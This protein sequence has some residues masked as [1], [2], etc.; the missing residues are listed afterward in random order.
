[1]DAVL[2]WSRATDDGELGSLPRLLMGHSLGGLIAAESALRRPWG[3]SGLV[4]SSPGFVVGEDSPAPLRAMA[5]LVARLL[6]W[7]PVEKLE[8]DDM[9]RVPEY[10]ADYEADPLVHHGGVPARSAGTML[11]GGRRFLSRCGALRTPTLLLGG[12]ADT[13]TA[14]R[15]FRRFATEAG[16]EHDP[17]PEITYREL[18]GGRHEVLNDLCAD[19]AYSALGE[20]LDAR[21][22]CSAG[23]AGAAGGPVYAG[24]HATRALLLPPPRRREGARAVPDRRRDAAHGGQRPHLRVRPRARD[25]D[26]GQ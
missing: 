17:R 1:R 24:P 2:A 23:V 6:P 12:S 13:V 11:A 5:P 16:S 19:E 14:P 15:G 10:V 3:L 21:L 9:S 22:A 26:P 20:W 4:L 18:E 8:P 25:A 7:L